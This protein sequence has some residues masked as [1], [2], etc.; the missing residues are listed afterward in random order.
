MKKSKLFMAI[1]ALCSL[2]T[3]CN[4]GAKDAKMLSQLTESDVQISRIDP[5][6]WYVGMKGPSL[7]LMVYGQGIR[8]AEVKVSGAKLDSVVRLDSPNYL[9]VYLNVK[10][11]KAGTLPLTFK[12]GDKKTTVAYQLKEREKAGDERMGFTNADVLYMLMPD[13]FAQ[14]ENHP[15]QIEGMNTYREDRSQP[16]LR[17]GGDLEGIRQHLDYF[18][19]L[20]V[21]ALWFTPVLENNSPDTGNGFS[22]YHGYATTD[23]Y[24]VD[25][26]FGTNEQ[27]RSLIADAHKKGL[28]VVMD[29]IFNH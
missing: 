9:L 29:M 18:N 7:Q 23:Y 26:R 13:R 10:G 22:T 4:N 2:M 11:C 3:S 12:L 5:T 14:G 16:S 6:D 17:H 25:P 20:G 19:E 1:T 27:Y 21:T 28:K 15:A 8:E 24:R